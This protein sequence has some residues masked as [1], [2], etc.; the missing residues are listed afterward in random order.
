MNYKVFGKGKPVVLIHGFIEE[1]SMWNETA[2]VLSKKFKIIVPDLD[3]FGSSPLQKKILSVEYY[4]DELYSL[5]K[6]EK[7]KK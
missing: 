3:G 1:G 7:I 2:K 5:L 6:R 4:A